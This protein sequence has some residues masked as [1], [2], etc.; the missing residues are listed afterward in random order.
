[1]FKKILLKLYMNLNLGVWRKNEQKSVKNKKLSH[2]TN[3]NEFLFVIPYFS[4]LD[5][6]KLTIK[7][8]IILFGFCSVFRIFYSVF[9]NFLF[10]LP[11]LH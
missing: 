3:K 4:V 9:T 8:K 11:D 2:Q 1:M 10:F 6:T 5:L 7:Q